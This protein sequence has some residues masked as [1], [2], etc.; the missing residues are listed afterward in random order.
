MKIEF[1]EN[2]LD[3]MERINTDIRNGT[4][5]VP[6]FMNEGIHIT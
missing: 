4:R 5:N 3:Y 2:D 6:L 1:N